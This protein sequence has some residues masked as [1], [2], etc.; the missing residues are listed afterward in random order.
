MA[1][2]TLSRVQD[3]AHHE[4]SN[5][6]KKINDGDD[7][8]FFLSSIAYRN[9]MQWLIQL[10]RSMFP[11]SSVDGSSI[12]TCKLDSPPQLP[13][14]VLRLQNMLVN[15][16]DL[17]EHAPPDTGPRRFG[18]VAFREW[19]RLAEDSATGLLDGVLDDSQLSQPPKDSSQR[20]ALREELKAYLIGSFGSA[21][22][23][24]YGTGHELSFL[25]FLGCLWK[26]GLLEEGE[27]RAIVV[28][29]IQP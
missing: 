16:T 22:R 4:F 27:E 1:A 24:D 8:N 3:L 14:N 6:V 5:P 19:F 13:S 26:I 9:L 15:L 20:T 28:G 23:L 10:T 21:Q 18:N 7:L 29:V 11:Q 12:S 2:S 17:I 25:A